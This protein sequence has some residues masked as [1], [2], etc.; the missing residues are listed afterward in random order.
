VDL[1]GKEFLGTE[2]GTLG[3]TLRA[4]VPIHDGNAVIGTVSVG[5]LESR[6]TAELNESLS[7]LLPW[8]L[9][10]LL[11]G[12]VASSLL[13]AAF[14]RRLRRLEEIGIEL[15][16]Q[17]RTATALREQTHEFH[18]RMHVIHGLVSHGDTAE[19]LSYVE[20]IAPLHSGSAATAVDTHPM[21]RAVIDALAAELRAAGATLETDLAV[22]SSVDDEVLLVIAN[23]CRNAGE[24]DARRVRLTLAE[25]NA[26]LRGTVEDDG[27]GVPLALRER[28][29]SRGVTSK[30]DV[31]GTGRGIG[32]DLVRRI[33]VARRGTIEVGAS[34]W[35]GSRFE[36]ELPVEEAV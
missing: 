15:E 12:T 21:L 34:A 32:L 19:A 16:Q 7:Q 17:R 28:I 18:T 33:V 11:L 29:F 27:P 6:I 14:A 26:G 23:L 31:T 22:T 30:H 13:S 3:P 20:R 35:G 10:A 8:T 36:F 24:S 1:N 25:S 4:K 2:E 5:I 9:G